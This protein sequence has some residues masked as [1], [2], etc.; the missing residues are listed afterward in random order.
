MNIVKSWQALIPELYGTQVKAV[1]HLNIECGTKLRSAEISGMKN[2][3]RKIDERVYNIMLND[4]ICYM[5]IGTPKIRKK[6][7]LELSLPNR[8]K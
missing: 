6:L 8:P 3:T 2:G 7:I 1:K 4:V 5:T